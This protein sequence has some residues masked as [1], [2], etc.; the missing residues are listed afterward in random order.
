MNLWNILAGLLAF[1]VSSSL[2][3]V[4]WTPITDWIGAF[5]ANLRIFTTVAFFGICFIAVVY[6]PFMFLVADDKGQ[7]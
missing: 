5:D 4:M 3:W 2:I 6:I 1:I 7:A